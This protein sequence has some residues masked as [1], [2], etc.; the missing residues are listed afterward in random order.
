ME[1][2][3]GTHDMDAHGFALT[4]QPHEDSI[5]LDVSCFKIEPLC[6][7][8]PDCSFPLVISTLLG[9][10]HP[11]SMLEYE[12]RRPYGHPSSYHS[13]LVT[14]SISLRREGR[15]YHLFR[16]F[17]EYLT[18]KDEFSIVIIGL[19]NVSMPSFSWKQAD[20]VRRRE[21][22][23]VLAPGRVWMVADRVG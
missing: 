1:E 8:S 7:R 13:L 10:F 22:R 20:G 17:H 16:G 21:R 4:I 6:A 3:E 15:M 23:S 11:K 2:E 19:D 5:L 9:Y 18:R 12:E 14:G